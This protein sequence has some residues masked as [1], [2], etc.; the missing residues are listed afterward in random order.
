MG[1]EIMASLSETTGP[2]NGTALRAALWAAQLLVGPPFLL[3]AWIKLTT[4]IPELAQSIAWAGEYPRFVRLMGAIDALGGL[5]LILPAATRIFPRL[6]VFAAAGCV[7]LQMSAIVFHFSRGE[8]AATPMNF[9]FLALSAFILWG[10]AT[11]ASI[12]PRSSKS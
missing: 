2:K 1:S 5:G 7:A 8:A 4:P 3:I 10:R 11:R 6:T 12:A 9:V